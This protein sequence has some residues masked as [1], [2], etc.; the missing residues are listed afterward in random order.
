MRMRLPPAVL[1][2]CD[3]PTTAVK[4]GMGFGWRDLD[5]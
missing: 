2:R 1:N 4:G 5:M 3:S